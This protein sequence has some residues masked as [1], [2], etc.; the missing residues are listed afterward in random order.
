MI[1]R[2]TQ[3]V[4]PA[5]IPRRVNNLLKT[6]RDLHYPTMRMTDIGDMVVAN[7]E[8]FKF[9]CETQFLRVNKLAEDDFKHLVN[10]IEKLDL[11]QIEMLLNEI[12][13]YKANLLYLLNKK[14]KSDILAQEMPATPQKTERQWI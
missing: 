10:Q 2:I 1:W 6:F 12:L 4:I 11:E 13:L 8:E 14:K 7:P 5:I 9:F 3:E